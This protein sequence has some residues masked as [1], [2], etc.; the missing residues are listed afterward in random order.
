MQFCDRISTKLHNK[1]LCATAITGAKALNI[2]AIFREIVFL[3]Q[4]LEFNLISCRFQVNTQVIPVV[5][6]LFIWKLLKVLFNSRFAQIIVPRDPGSQDTIFL[7]VWCNT[8]D[9][10]FTFLYILYW[11]HLIF[12]SNFSSIYLIV[13]N[14]GF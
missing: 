6:N 4:L 7:R 14:L 5:Y 9:S 8:A 2:I 12:H 11:D 13:C 1:L 3:Q 10:N